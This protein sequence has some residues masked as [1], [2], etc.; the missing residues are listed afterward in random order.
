MRY[1]ALATDYDGTLARDSGV[2]ENIIEALKSFKASGRYLIMVTGRE[3]DELK[4][5]FPHLDLFDRVVAENGALLYRPETFEEKPVG[6]KPPDEFVEN[7]KKRGVGPISVGRVIVATWEPHDKTVLEVIR[8]M[9]LELQVIF[10]KGAVMILPSG[11]NKAKGLGVALEELGLSP[12]NVIG[13]GDAE[14]DHAFLEA[15]ECAVAVSNALE[16]LKDKADII[17]KADHGDGVV[18][19][20]NRVLAND[21]EDITFTNRKNN[22]NIGVKS[23]GEELSLK[24][25]GANIL[26]AGSSGG[27]KSTL[28][29]SFLEILAEKKYQFCLIDPEGDYLNFGGAIVIGNAKTPP[30][31]EEIKKIL[32]QPEQNIVI[33]TLAITVEDRPNFFQKLFP[34]LMEFRTRL[35]RPHWLIFD[36]AHHLFPE[37]WGTTRVS[38]PKDLKNIF[39]I[40]LDPNSLDKT[41]LNQVNMLIALGESPEKTISSFAR[42]QELEVPKLP[43]ASLEKLDGIAWFRDNGEPFWMRFYPPKTERLR[44]I[45]KYF[46]GE[47]LPDENFY[48]R[49]P[50]GKMNLRVQNLSIFLQ[51]SEGIDDETWMFHLKRKDYSKW[52]K[53]VIKDEVLADYTEKIEEEE[54]CTPEQSRKEIKGLI[55]KRYSV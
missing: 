11:I 43:A 49:G 42:N 22:L 34:V 19:L 40:T 41:I 36:E 6:K 45:R 25:Y 18:E 52:F 10:N 16:T 46:T 44:H 38:I 9:G 21:L 35:S 30:I 27:G 17:T 50:E 15:S 51:I 5:V 7:L 47:L 55:E 32:E 20:I 28:T 1:H 13:I 2:A 33:C 12:H 26:V 48:F 24:P 4:T 23:N 14:N 53:S 37:T 3:L 29:T 54:E 39:M 8:E 31:I